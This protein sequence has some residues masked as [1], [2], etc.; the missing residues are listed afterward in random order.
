MKKRSPGL[1][2]ILLAVSVLSGC[3]SQRANGTSAPTE[4]ENFFDDIGYISRDAQ[5]TEP[6]LPDLPPITEVPA[7][8]SGAVP[9]KFGAQLARSR[10]YSFPFDVFDA[11]P[12]EESGKSMGYTYP[13]EFDEPL[14]RCTGFT[15]EYEI[16]EVIHGNLSGNFRYDILVRNLEGTWKSA[17]IF[18][19]EGYRA[20]AEVT[21][22]EPMSIDAVAVTCGKQDESVA[23]SFLLTVKDP[24]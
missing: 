10:N 17:G 22:E 1:L 13:F 19:M 4:T 21:L 15:L 18:K 3:G 12:E 11:M 5:E 9:G 2:C 7:A 24:R 20:V 23:Y 14:R 6:V 16:M 8:D